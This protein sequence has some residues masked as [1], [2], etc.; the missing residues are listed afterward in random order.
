MVLVVGPVKARPSVGRRLVGASQRRPRPEFGPVASRP[1]VE[2]R[3]TA[4]P[5]KVPQHKTQAVKRRP[6]PAV[7]DGPR[8]Q[9]AGKTFSVAYRRKRRQRLGA[10]VSRRN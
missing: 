3:P 4:R 8:R 6:V 1:E 5:V 2:A 10:K 9:I 7:R